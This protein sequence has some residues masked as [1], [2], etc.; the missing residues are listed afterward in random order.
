MRKLTVFNF[1]TLNGF[2]KGP[3][4]DVSWHSHGAEEY[5]FAIE[6]IKSG[7]TLL[8]GRV[9]YQMMAGFWPTPMAIK[10]APEMAEGMNKAEKIVFS[11][12]LK[13]VTWNNTR[14]IKD[15]IEDEI[16]KMKNMPGKDLTLL[17][18]GS[19]LSQLAEQNLI[20]EFQLMIDP[21]ALPKGTSIFKG[22]RKELHFKL[23]DTKIFKGGT[24][25]LTYMPA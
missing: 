2:Y 6:R 23:T 9:T 3:K 21:V 16:K 14:I 22:I 10:N 19:I 5:E 17:G 24:I 13:K 18:S 8:F 20:D 15:T 25:L 7:N 12:T 11:K 4:E 1:V